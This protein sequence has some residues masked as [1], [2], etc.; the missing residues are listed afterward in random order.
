MQ[1]RISEDLPDQVLRA[2]N[3]QGSFRVRSLAGN[4]NDNYLIQTAE[5]TLVV[6]RLRSAYSIAETELEGVYRAR[7]ADSDL[8]VVKYVPLD[9][10]H[11]VLTV[12]DDNYVAAPYIKGNTPNYSQDLAR[13]TAE[14]LARVHSMPS[15]GLGERETWFREDYITDSLTRISNQFTKAKH[16]F[17]DRQAHIPDF[18]NANLPS[19]IVHGDLHNENIIVDDRGRIVSIIDWEETAIQPLL[20]DVAQ[21]A[22]FMSLRD[23]ICD[24]VTFYTFMNTYQH[25]RP[26]TELEKQWFEPALRYTTLALSVW[27]HLKVSEGQLDKATFDDLGSRYALSYVTPQIK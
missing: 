5:R 4:E 19:G 2:L 16:E 26:L 23:G 22:R 12:D 7:L 3:I 15:F 10:A 8:P 14:L 25:I 27:A 20:L 11:F 13:Q 24:V 9:A 1:Q 17:A 21:T 6:K 18:W